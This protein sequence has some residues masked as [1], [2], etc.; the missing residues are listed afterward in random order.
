MTQFHMGFYEDSMENYC[1]MCE[2]ENKFACMPK[3]YKQNIQATNIGHEIDD[4]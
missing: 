3:S 1:L 2:C 4:R